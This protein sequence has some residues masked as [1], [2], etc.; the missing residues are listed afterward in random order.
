MQVELK[1]SGGT[2]AEVLEQLK[3]FHNEI[4]Q[5]S[6]PAPA[7]KKPGKKAETKTDPA[8]AQEKAATTD[9]EITADTLRAAW[10]AKKDAG[11]K[12]ASI[13]GIFDKYGVKKVDEIKAE[14]FA[15]VL[16]DINAIK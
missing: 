14:D 2:T 6:T 15:A 8:P 4:G 13:I 7:D 11:A 9:S 16:A 5:G 3:A 10:A 12:T 1:F